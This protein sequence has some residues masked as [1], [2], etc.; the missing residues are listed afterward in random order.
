MV[1]I[2][3]DMNAAKKAADPKA[4]LDSAV[5]SSLN[6]IKRK[7]IVMSGKGGV[8]KSSTAVNLALA[9]ARMGAQVGLLD[10]DLHGPDIPRM[11]GLKGMLDMNGE[12]KL[13][14]K[15]YSPNLSAVSVESLTD[16][17]DEAIIWRGPVK[18]SVIQQFIGQVAWGN[19][20]FLLIDA[21]PGTGDEPLTIAQTIPDAQAVIVTTPQEVSLADVRKSINFCTTVKMSVFGLVENMSGLLCPHCNCS[22]DLFGSGGGERTAAQM[23]IPFLG[24]VPFDP[25]MVTCGDAGVAYQEQHPDSPVTLAYQA[26][27][28]RL[29]ASLES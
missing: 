22:I 15:R 14:P 16:G 23:S 6:N 26:I 7:L 12:Q 10:V 24:R 25:E 29:M 1:Q 27:A 9:L 8:G 28:D 20:D 3:Q 11:L 19:L 18:Y 13:V 21:P 4:A 2:H 17:R 5:K